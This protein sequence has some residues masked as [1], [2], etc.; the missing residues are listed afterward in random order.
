M[1]NTVLAYRDVPDIRPPDIRYR[2]VGIRYPVAKNP[3]PS[4]TTHDIRKCG[5]IDVNKHENRRKWPL[6]S[7]LPGIVVLYGIFS[8]FVNVIVVKHLVTSAKPSSRVGRQLQHFPP[9]C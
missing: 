5:K 2:I 7:R 3:E 6:L 4:S 1:H 8:Q 9:N